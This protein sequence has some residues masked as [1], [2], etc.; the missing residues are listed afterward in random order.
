MGRQPSIEPNRKCQICA[1]T[2]TFKN[3]WYHHD[4][5]KGFICQGC[6]SEEYRQAN[7]DYLSAQE[8]GRYYRKKLEAMEKSNKRMAKRIENKKKKVTASS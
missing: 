7:R 6:Y 3:K 5:K 2:A 4:N 1:S 8:L